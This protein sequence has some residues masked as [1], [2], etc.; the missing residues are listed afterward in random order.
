MADLTLRAVR[1]EHTDDAAQAA[2]GDCAGP[3]R[4]LVG[5]DGSPA[6]TEALRY[7]AR[8]ACASH[9]RLTVI[10]ALPHV[11]VGAMLAPVSVPGLEREAREAAERELAQGVAELDLHVSVTTVATC[12]GLRQALTRAWRSGEHDAV[13]LAAGGLLSGLCGAARA[14]R[15]V[16]VEP[17]VVGAEPRSGPPLVQRGRPRPAGQA[18]PA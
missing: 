3:Q 5:H 10:L 4:L 14:L 1:E 18:R 11:P 6:S 7:A 8:L 12:S 13:V 2:V 17:I 16:G 9:G 15:R